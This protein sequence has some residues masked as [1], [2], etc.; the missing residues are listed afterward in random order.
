MFRRRK[1][2]EQRIEAELREH[3]D[4]L[5][6]LHIDSG[7]DPDAARRQALIEFGNP[8]ALKDHCRDHRRFHW[9]ET[10]MADVRYG[11]RRLARAP[12]FT[13]VASLSLAIGI[14]AG[15]A[16]F[17][18]VNAAIIQLIQVRAPQELVWF[19]SGE[20]GR[21]L[22]YPFYELVRD[23]ERFDGVLSAFPTPIDFGHIGVDRSCGRG[24]RIGQLL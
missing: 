10:F 4:R 5:V 9:L 12:G 11:C 16:L 15:T 2:S 17:S 14:G 6:A 20:H 1:Y 21:A 3:L 22:S 19:H 24:T 13:A 8:E 18:V 7:M 23:D